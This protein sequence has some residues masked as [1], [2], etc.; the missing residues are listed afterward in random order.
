MIRYAPT[1]N[2]IFAATVLLGINQG[3]C[4][5]MTQAAKLDITRADQRCL[6]VGLNEFTGSVGVALARIAT[7][8]IAQIMG[9]RLGLLV[10]GLSAV[11]VA[12]ALAI[13][14]VKDT[15]PWALAEADARKTAAPEYS[16]HFQTGVS[17]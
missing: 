13:L 6:T 4:W 14:W 2:W 16:G 10:F 11:V 1:W 7:Y 12:L 8:Y 17:E 15:L 9:P 5:S 3:L